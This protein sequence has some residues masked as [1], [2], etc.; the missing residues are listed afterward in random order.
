V[1]GLIAGACSDCSQ[2]NPSAVS[3]CGSCCRLSALHLL[4]SSSSACKRDNE[5]GKMQG[6]TQVDFVD[7]DSTPLAC[8]EDVSRSKIDVPLQNALGLSLL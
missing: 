8:S 4:F 1:L 2:H 7:Q 6:S 5:S 3:D